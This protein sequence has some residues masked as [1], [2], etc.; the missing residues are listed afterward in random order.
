MILVPPFPT[1]MLRGV[2]IR[3][4]V[5]LPRTPDHPVDNHQQ[6]RHLAILGGL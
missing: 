2:G 3:W 1:Y 5:T 6:G 4:F